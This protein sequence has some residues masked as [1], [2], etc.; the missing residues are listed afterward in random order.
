MARRSKIEDMVRLADK[1]DGKCLSN[2]YV[3]AKTP[4]IWQC[5][6]GHKWQQRPHDIVIG[7]W[8]KICAINSSKG[9]IEMMQELAANKSGKC[10]SEYYQNQRSKLSWK[11]E[12]GHIWKATPNSIKSGSWCPECA[13]NSRKGT[14]EKMQ[15]LATNKSGKCISEYYENETSNLSWECKKRHIW[16]ATPKSIKSGSWCPECTRKSP[17]IAGS[18]KSV[19]T[20]QEMNQMAI[21][22]GGKCISEYYENQRSQLSWECEKGHV[23]NSTPK[24]I[25]SGSWCPECA[26]NSRRKGTIEKMQELATNKGGKCLSKNY[27]NMHEKLKWECH[28]GHVWDTAPANI[29]KGAWCPICLP[30]GHNTRLGLKHAKKLALNKGGECLSSEYKNTGEPLK[31]QCE[32]G[33]VWEASMDN[34]K[35]GNT[36][37]PYCS[38]K[39]NWSIEKL[40][41]Y[42]IEKG[43]KCLAVEYVRQTD[44]VEWE[45][46]DG[47]RWK[48]S[49]GSMISQN[50]W[51]PKC[52]I[53]LSEE[54]CRAHFETLFDAKFPNTKPSWLLSPKNRKMELDGYNEKLK[55]AFEHQGRHHYSIGRFSESKAKLTSRQNY[56]KVKRKRC[57]EMGVL[58]IEIPELDYMLPIAKLR[59]YIKSCLKDGNRD[60][61]H[62]FDFKTVDLSSINNVS[63]LD[64]LKKIAE[65]KGGHCLSVAW[66]GAKRR[67]DFMCSK[68]H[69][70]KAQAYEIYSAGTWCPI[71]YRENQG[72]KQLSRNIEEKWQRLEEVVKSKGGECIT[73]KW[74]GANEY[75]EFKCQEGHIWKAWAN[76]I[77]RGTWCPHCRK[78]DKTKN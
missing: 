45:C 43:G 46:K 28:L 32:S 58:L 16:E 54:I 20:I 21:D 13:I 1:R 40:H 11:C 53:Y 47:H 63:R 34:I 77:R 8:C 2:I 29:K 23:W 56:D 64:N 62:N 31:W 12:K 67:H 30:R 52:H 10:I 49:P 24:N 27:S 26:I 14:I 60:I 38:G 42:A 65:S 7:R 39:H 33:H 50:Q 22:K 3:N 76:N 73:R 37:C 71:C 15:E 25:K 51:C 9:S 59:E 17:K 19:L 70:W 69:E 66:L 41:N 74:L 61:P 72:K 55:I 78:Q 68:G 35:Y 75:H 44:A 18:K 4:L 5:S 48:R 6:E 36:W 57:K